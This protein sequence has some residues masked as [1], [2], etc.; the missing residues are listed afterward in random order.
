MPVTHVRRINATFPAV[1]TSDEDWEQ[2]V[3]GWLQ[4][5][6]ANEEQTEQTLA[7]IRTQVAQQ[8][9]KPWL[10]ASA[11]GLGAIPPQDFITDFEEVAATSALDEI[12]AER[13]RQ[14]EKGY[15]AAH[16]DAHG[17]QHLIEV[18]TSYLHGFGE[19]PTDEF[20]GGEIIKAAATLT[21]A[22]DLLSRTSARRAA[23]G[24]PSA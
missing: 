22:L 13:M 1:H 19:T 8:V 4:Q 16:D 3:T 24:E 7:S 17:I 11:E 20:V 5:Y 15:D 23:L 14:I 21:A 18:A 12:F 6:G 10:I 9:A 2:H